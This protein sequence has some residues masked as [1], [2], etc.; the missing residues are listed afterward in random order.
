MPCLHDFWFFGSYAALK[1]INPDVVI[2]THSPYINLVVAWLYV[3]NNSE[4]IL[5]VDFGDLWTANRRSLGVPGVRVIE[6]F[7]EKRILHCAKIVTS[8]SAHLC[9]KLKKLA[10]IVLLWCIT[11]QCSSFKIK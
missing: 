2:A 6:L 11:H 4:K 9:E 7:L 10:R 3:R 5:W 8:V 1:K